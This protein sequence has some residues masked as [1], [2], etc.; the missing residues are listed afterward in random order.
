MSCE[1][2]DCFEKVCDELLDSIYHEGSILYAKTVGSVTPTRSIQQLIQLKHSMYLGTATDQTLDNRLNVASQFAQ[3]NI[4]S[5]TCIQLTVFIKL[6]QAELRVGHVTSAQASQLIQGA[7]NIQTALG[8]TAR[9]GI[10]VSSLQASPTS[11]SR[12]NNL[13]QAK[14]PQ[15]TASSPSLFQPQSRS[16][17]P[18]PNKYRYPSQN[19][20]SQSPQNQQLPPVANAGVSQTVNENTKVTLDGRASY[21]PT[22]GMIVAFQWTQLSTTGV[23]VLIVQANT[24]TPTLLS[25]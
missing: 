18:Y 6:V 24:A 23:P 9:N 5:G 8:C 16:P 13:T 4:K 22:G 2:R 20:Q 14:Q 11:S 7:Q 21:S 12:N 1:A 10:V 17:Y 3:N 15:T 25:P 19:P